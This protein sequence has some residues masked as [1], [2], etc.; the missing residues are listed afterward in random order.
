M[1]NHIPNCHLLTNKLGLVNS[2]REY[3]RM[4]TNVKKKS[5]KLDFIPETYKLDD[6]NE[7]ELFY[8]LFTGDYDAR[9]NG[10]SPIY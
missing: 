10:Y 9:L 1:V 7:R 5:S 3:D 4:C 8:E 6:K 2:L